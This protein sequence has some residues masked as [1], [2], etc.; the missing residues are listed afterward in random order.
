VDAAAEAV[1]VGVV[2]A[3]CNCLNY[4]KQTWE[5]CRSARYPVVW[6]VIDNGSVDYG[7]QFFRD[8]STPEIPV[9]VIR[10]NR[11]IG[12]HRAWNAGIRSCWEQDCDV[13]LVTGNDVVFHSLA[14]DNLVRWV[15]EGEAFVTVA[16]VLQEPSQLE[17][18]T[19]SHEW[20]PYPSYNA[21][22]LTRE[23][24]EKNLWFDETLAIPEYVGDLFHHETLVAAG[25]PAGHVRDAVVA[26]YGSRAIHEGGVRVGTAQAH[27]MA[28]FITRYGYD[29][30]RLGTRPSHLPPTPPRRSAVSAR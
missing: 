22:M 24:T 23:V 2:M 13:A 30:E 26:H 12:V 10:H 29:P 1:K 4:S 8:A 25:I 5:S 18:V 9:R 20:F 21:F 15:E 17:Q 28:R 16:P 7:F 19:L 14:L 27:N 3:V 11:N 6:T